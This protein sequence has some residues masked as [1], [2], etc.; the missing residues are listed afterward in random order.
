[1]RL[2]QLRDRYEAE[3]LEKRRN[4]KN[5]YKAEIYTLEETVLR[6]AKRHTEEY[7]QILSPFLERWRTDIAEY[8]P[9]LLT[10]AKPHR[11]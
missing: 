1:M 7:E 11:E 6:H 4:L 10:A 8:V 3:N 5:L 9:R 2:K